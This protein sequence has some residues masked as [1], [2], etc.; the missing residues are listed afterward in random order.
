M[1]VLLVLAANL[2]TKKAE[3]LLDGHL[4]EDEE[5]RAAVAPQHP[6]LVHADRE[7]GELPRAQGLC[8]HVCGKW[9]GKAATCQRP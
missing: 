6:A 7:R 4:S 1:R 2:T 5:G 8:S 9:E 3:K